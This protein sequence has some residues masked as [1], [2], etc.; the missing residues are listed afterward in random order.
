[1]KYDPTQKQPRGIERT[2]HA[3]GD[4]M[5]AK[6]AEKPFEKISVGELCAQ[7]DYPRATFYNYFDDKYDLVAFC[8]FQLSQYLHLPEVQ[9]QPSNSSLLELFDQ[10]Y[11]IFAEHQPLLLA[12][13]E[14][15]PLDSQLATNFIAHF[16]GV[17][18]ALIKDRL[19]FTLTKTPPDLLAKHYSTTV[20]LILEWIFLGQHTTTLEEAE[21]YLTALLAP[22]TGA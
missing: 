1:M 16:T 14:H 5:F 17:V 2:M 19:R 7:A 8:W 12:I 10:A 11:A 15:N 13:I 20:L 4:A 22:P 18:E 9:A 6:L 3:F 21:R